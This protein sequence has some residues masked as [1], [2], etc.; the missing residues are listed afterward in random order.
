MLGNVA[1]QYTNSG[2]M[3]F[4]YGEATFEN[5]T[6][7]SNRNHGF[8][9]DGKGGAITS[10]HCELR[11]STS[12]F[13]NNEAYYGKDI[14]LNNDLLTY[15]SIFKHS[16]TLKSNDKNFKQKVFEDNIFWTA[17]PQDVIISETL[18]ASG[19]IFLYFQS[20]YRTHYA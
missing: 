9:N 5:C 11:I 15:L 16:T 18:Y 8:K 3:V 12:I 20:E 14:F 7:S 17:D 1:G 4:H 13:D 19:T 10:V 6:F 2:C